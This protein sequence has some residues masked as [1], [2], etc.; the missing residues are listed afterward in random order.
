M[1]VHPGRALL[2]HHVVIGFHYGELVSSLT[3]VRQ[4]ILFLDVR[5]RHDVGDRVLG[6]P[7][8][9]VVLESSFI[10]DWLGPIAAVNLL[11]LLGGFDVG[12]Q[13]LIAKNICS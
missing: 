1:V 3:V 4:R 2:E 6:I 5:E 9:P 10:G 12:N 7:Y 8:C 13:F 11:G